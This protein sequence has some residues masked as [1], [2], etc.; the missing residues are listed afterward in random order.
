VEEGGRKRKGSVAERM[1][2]GS[3]TVFD[4]DDEDLISLTV[5]LLFFCTMVGW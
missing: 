4:T 5:L 3:D 1:W 2:I